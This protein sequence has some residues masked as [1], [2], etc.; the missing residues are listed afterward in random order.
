MGGCP[1]FSDTKN[2][3]SSVI[4]FAA[5]G[6]QIYG[7]C[8]DDNGTVRKAISSYVVKVGDRQPVN[9][10]TT[11]DKAYVASAQYDGQFHG[12]YEYIEG[13]DDLDASN[14]MMVDGSYGYYVTE[15]YPWVM[16]CFSGSPDDSF[17]KRRR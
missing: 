13:K 1:V 14:G 11:P 7:S 12:D 3:T 2:V 4:G 8:F 10:L 5:N 17:A 9:G 16:G 6:F 15:S